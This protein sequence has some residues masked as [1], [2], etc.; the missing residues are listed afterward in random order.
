VGTGVPRPSRV[1][2]A[3]K[4]GTL[5]A[6]ARGSVVNV[7]SE[8]TT[9]SGIADSTNAA[10]VAAGV[11]AKTNQERPSTNNEVN[12]TPSYMEAM[13]TQSDDMR[14]ALDFHQTHQPKAGVQYSWAMEDAQATNESYD[15]AFN[16]VDAKA[17]SILVYF[18]SGTGLLTAGL[19]VPLSL[20]GVSHWVGVT[21]LPAFA[22]ALMALWY[23]MSCRW[24]VDMPGRPRVES[25][26][27]ALHHFASENE[28]KGWL[29]GQWA[30]SNAGLLVATN[31]K[32]TLVRKASENMFRSIAFLAL[33]LVVCL[34]IKF[35]N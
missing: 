23:A 27:R 8:P 28:A 31:R 1:R 34:A 4:R 33:P 24:P 18:G 20:G 3:E 29:L 21:I 6:H 15:A 22:S 10:A 2:P 35:F 12:R 16:D 5:N 19:L 32:S 17:L 25:T 14:S 9:T 30:T 13:A 26:V 7:A 11:P